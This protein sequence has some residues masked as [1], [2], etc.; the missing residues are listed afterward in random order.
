MRIRCR[1]PVFI[2]GMLVLVLAFSFACNSDISNPFSLDDRNQIPDAN[3]G[4]PGD[5]GTPE[6]DSGSDAA[7]DDAS[8]A[9]S[10]KDGGV[11]NDAGNDAGRDA[12]N[13]AGADAGNDAGVDAGCDSG[14]DAG[15]FHPMDNLDDLELY[16]NIGDSMGAGYN[17]TDRNGSGGKGYARLMLDNHSDYPVY[18]DHHLRALFK[19]VQFK[20]IARSGDK[21]EDQLSDLKT[22]IWF[23]PL[24]SGDVLVSLTCGG[25][26]FNN[27]IN[28][29]MFRSKTEEAAQKLQDNYREIFRL[30]REKYDKS[31]QKVV[32]LVTNVTDPTGG[33]G[34]IP[35][36]LQEGFCKTINNPLFTP[37]LRKA[38][39]ENLQFF[40]QKIAGV[41]AELGGYLVD[42]H[43]VFLEHGMNVPDKDRWLDI[44]CVH[45]INEGH[46][47]LRREEWFVLTGER[48]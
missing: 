47:Q 3:N 24:V 36:T 10:G 39:M 16:I 35:W 5:G 15:S 20:D 44:D 4:Q 45:P 32:F 21:S 1:I 48:W 46:N 13:D 19:D 2:T 8:A 11:A 43:G 7:Q 38:A 31:G 37:L 17:A 27:D 41:V 18:D 6:K 22:Q 12:G 40:N 23:F 33:T 9:D 29:M 25:N 14:F 42:S 28:I 26:D 30:I 34:S